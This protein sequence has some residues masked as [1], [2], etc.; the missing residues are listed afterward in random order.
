MSRWPKTKEVSY[1]NLGLSFNSLGQSSDLYIYNWRFISAEALF[2]PRFSFLF[3]SA[4]AVAGRLQS[5]NV[6]PCFPVPINTAIAPD[7]SS[8]D[9]IKSSLELSG[10][11]SSYPA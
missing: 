1:R 7:N 11:A 10:E 6:K 3:N 2:R 4:T 5:P 8:L 9:L